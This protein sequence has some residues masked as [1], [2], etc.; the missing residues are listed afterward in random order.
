MSFGDD[1]IKYN[2]AGIADYTHGPVD[3][4]RRARQHRRAGERTSW[5]ALHEYF[6]TEHGATAYTAGPAD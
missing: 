2:P 3:L 4:Q 6:D 5:P 1:V